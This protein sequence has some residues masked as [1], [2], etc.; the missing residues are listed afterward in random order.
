MKVQ[1]GAT[2]YDVEHKGGGTSKGP[3]KNIISDVGVVEE[4]QS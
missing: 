4:A 2:A 1:D 3:G